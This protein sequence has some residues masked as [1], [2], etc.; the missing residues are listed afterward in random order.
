[1]P[2]LPG[3]D[4]IQIVGS[5]CPLADRKR[6]LVD[7]QGTLADVRN[8]RDEAKGKYMAAKADYGKWCDLVR[9]FEALAQQAQ[10]DINSYIDQ[11]QIVALS[12]PV[13]DEEVNAILDSMACELLCSAHPHSTT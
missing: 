13:L 4:T 12:T 11:I 8:D 7:I 1:M 6:D 5:D 9:K 2:S 3:G 10:A